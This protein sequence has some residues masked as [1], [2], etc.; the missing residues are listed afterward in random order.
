MTSLNGVVAGVAAVGAAAIAGRY[1]LSASAPGQPV[2]AGSI[3]TVLVIGGAFAGVSTASQLT[4]RLKSKAKV[5]L[6]DE[7]DSFFVAVEAMKPLLDPKKVDHVWL[8]Y[9]ARSRISAGIPKESVVQGRAMKLTENVLELHDGR[10]L[11]FDFAVVATGTASAL[12]PD[13]LT[14]AAGSEEAKRLDRALR[15]AKTIAIVGGGQVGV[16]LAAKLCT[17]LPNAKIEM[18]H[19][20]TKL[21]PNMAGMTDASRE[22]V[23]SSMQKFPNLSVHLQDTLVPA[24]MGKG[25][26]TTQKLLRSKAGEKVQ[27]DITFYTT[28]NTPNSEFVAVGLGA[29]AVDDKGYVRTNLD[30]SLVGHTRIFAAGDVSTMDD[31]KLARQALNQGAMIASNIE[32][33]VNAGWFGERAELADRPVLKQYAPSAKTTAAVK[34]AGQ[35]IV[36]NLWGYTLKW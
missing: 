28:G 7:R 33:L 11:A 8:D 20:G 2:S 31:V 36:A 25:I 27:A 32:T 15:A 10:K 34:L 21:L 12:K 3:P 1:F 16:E 26:I 24:D 30:G 9:T 22:A 35:G 18:F 14:K 13:A 5:V 6:V 4:N 23:L 17:E 19:R 29:N